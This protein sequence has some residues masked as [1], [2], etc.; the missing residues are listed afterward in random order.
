MH[1]TRTTDDNKGQ[2]VR[3]TLFV[4][5]RELLCCCPGL[6]HLESDNGIFGVNVGGH[7]HG[8]FA[9]VKD[10]LSPGESSF[11]EAGQSLVAPKGQQGCDKGGY[12]REWCQGYLEPL[13]D[14][15]FTTAQDNG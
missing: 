7:E 6:T 3:S 1:H 12:Q 4:V 15:Q 13:Q 14:A 11:G 5:L 2:G 10:G 9:G 8:H